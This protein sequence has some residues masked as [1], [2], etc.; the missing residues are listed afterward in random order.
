MPRAI[1]DTT[2]LHHR[3]RNL[4]GQVFG[5]LTVERPSESRNGKTFWM[6]VC[7]CGNRKEVQA[8]ELTRKRGGRA[9]SCGCMTRQLQSRARTTHGKTHTAMYYTWRAMIDRC[10][11]PSHAAYHNY[12]GRGIGVCERWQ[13]F[14]NFYADMHAG[15]AKG[16][17]LDRRDNEAGYSP[18]NCRWVDR[19]TQ[20]NNK[21]GNV[22][23]LTPRGRMTVSQ[24]AETFGIGVTTILYR[25][26]AGWPEHLL[27]IAPDF[28]N[29]VAA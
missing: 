5:F 18:G 26:S 2:K 17:T 25:I 10:R 12:G 8:S 4:T 28:T 29:R 7:V 22:W 19:K 6:A 20:A 27:L 13:R 14:E 21:R 3:A 24:A 11:L 23:I 1:A 15:Y 9:P 16:L